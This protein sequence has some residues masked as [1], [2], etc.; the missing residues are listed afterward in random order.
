M[1]GDLT[2]R[3]RRLVAHTALAGVL[4]ACCALVLMPPERFAL[5][6]QCPI[7]EYL[8]LLCPGCGATRALSALLHGHLGEALRLNLL[9]VLLLPFLLAIA[10]RT[11]QRAISPSSFRW[12]QVP[13]SALAA[14]LLI[15]L[16]FTV[17]RNM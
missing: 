14:A 3:K 16:V 4:L 11:Y 2:L 8:G 15:T 6:P 17:A 1:S 13:N 12:P 5:Y 9:F 10:M 7:H